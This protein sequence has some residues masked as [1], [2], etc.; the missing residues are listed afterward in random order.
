LS[1]LG[2]LKVTK[3]GNLGLLLS[4]TTIIF[5]LVLNELVSKRIEKIRQKRIQKNT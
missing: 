3:I 5:A 4:I 1:C 2:A